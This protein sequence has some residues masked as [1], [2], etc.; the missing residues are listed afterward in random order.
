MI[1]FMFP[2]RDHTVWS[3]P[4]EVCVGWFDAN[5]E[6]TDDEVLA[7][8]NPS[9]RLHPSQEVFFLRR[10]AAKVTGDRWMSRCL[11]LIDVL[12]AHRSLLLSNPA[13]L[14]GQQTHYKYPLSPRTPLTLMRSCPRGSF[15]PSCP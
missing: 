11:G 12:P 3:D 5:K 6:T 9:L 15:T 7:G 4:Q 1:L 8:A 14:N 10:A 13:S 2:G